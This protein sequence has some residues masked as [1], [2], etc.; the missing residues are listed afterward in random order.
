M[1][2]K[3]PAAGH[4]ESAAERLTSAYR[5]AKSLGAK[6]IANQCATTTCRVPNAPCSYGHSRLFPVSPFLAHKENPP[7]VLHALA[8]GGVDALVIAAHGRPSL[9]RVTI[10]SSART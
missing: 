8:R 1:G 2:R 5:T 7:S 6:P 4:R 3:L 10:S 9:A